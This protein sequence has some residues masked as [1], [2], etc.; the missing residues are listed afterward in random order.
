[1]YFVFRSALQEWE[2][3]V[4]QAKLEGSPIT[5][6][7]HLWDSL[8]LTTQLP[9]I[10][11]TTRQ[12]ALMLDNYFTGTI[13]DLYS[14]DLINLL[15]QAGI[16]FEQFP[17]LVI[18]R[19]TRKP[20]QKE[21]KIFHL[22]EKYSGLDKDLTEIHDDTKEIIKLV[23]TDQC[24]QSG[25]PLFRLAESRNIVLIHLELKQSLELHNISGCRYIPLSEYCEDMH[26]YFDKLRKS[27]K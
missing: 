27:D 11:F 22:L 14:T 20:S 17:A 19:T 4:N 8:P 9:L 18:D 13:F 24:L 26:F 25:K 21:Y 23:L 10:T 1:M 12:N 5:T 2:N 6:Q 3:D 7:P 15:S 16:R